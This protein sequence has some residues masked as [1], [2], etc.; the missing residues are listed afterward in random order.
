MHQPVG[1]MH[2][3][4]DVQANRHLYIY[5]NQLKICFVSYKWISCHLVISVRCMLPRTRAA[6]PLTFYSKSSKFLLF[7]AAVVVFVC[8]SCC[9]PVER[10]I[11]Q[12]SRHH[13]KNKLLFVGEIEINV[14]K[15]LRIV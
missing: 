10:F 5:I 1:D 2:I 4:N 13:R 9:T 11:C 14:E 6:L 15:L 8:I 12:H 3:F 7:V